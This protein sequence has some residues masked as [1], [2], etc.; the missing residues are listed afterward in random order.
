MATNEFA[1]IATNAAVDND[2]INLVMTESPMLIGVA[3]SQHLG[4]AL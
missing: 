4:V 2:S 1:A 3:N